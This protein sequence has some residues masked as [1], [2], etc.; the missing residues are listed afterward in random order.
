VLA[1]NPEALRTLRNQ[2][3][4][5]RTEVAHQLGVSHFTV[6]WWEQGRHVPKDERLLA[7]AKLFK[8]NVVDFY[9]PTEPAGPVA[10]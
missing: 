8:C 1:F 10:V 7:L 5:S 3:G 6:A 2:A 9:R 4:M